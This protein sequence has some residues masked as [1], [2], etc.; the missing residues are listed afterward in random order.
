VRSLF[1]ILVVII[2]P[3]VSC[4][5]KSDD[6]VFKGVIRNALTGEVVEGETVEILQYTTFTSIPKNIGTAVTGNDGAYTIR[7]KRTKTSKFVINISKPGYFSKST[8]VDVNSIKVGENTNDFSINAIGYMKFVIKRTSSLSS[9]QFK[10]FRQG[11]NT[12]CS[13]CCSA[14]ASFMY[15]AIDTVFYCPANAGS[16]FKFDWFVNGTQGFGSENYSIPAF[17]TVTFTKIF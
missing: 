1:L 3:N 17:D 12:S 16:S 4:K 10:L 7:T 14:G 2:L 15:G 13:E 6:Y 5:K 11:S 8:D 9:D